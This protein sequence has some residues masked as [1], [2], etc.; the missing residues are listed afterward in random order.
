MQDWSLHSQDTGGYFQCNRFV[1]NV[2]SASGRDGEE[3]DEDELEGLGLGSGGGAPV[4]SGDSRE[5]GQRMKE[6]GN[7]MA[8]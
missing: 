3:D 7:A 6:K 5:E 8:R 4:A 1:E 2:Q